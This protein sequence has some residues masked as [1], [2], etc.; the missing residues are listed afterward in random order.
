MKILF[1]GVFDTEHK[2]TN[3]SQLIAFKELGHD[4]VGYNYRK[5][6][7]LIGN[8]NRDKDLISIVKDRNFDLVVYSKCN[9]VSLETF[10]QI[11]EL[12]KTCLWF[13]DPLIT[14]EQEMREKTKLVDYFCCDKEN[15]LKEALKINKNSF[16]VC[17]GFD[18]HV[19]KPHSL[20][21]CYDISFIG[22]IYGDRAKKLES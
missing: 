9:V 6:G 15:V 21:K 17:E 11:N 14:Y 10:R 7:A 1:I 20:E 5:K 18:H 16:H 12:T 19:D 22:S 3:L 8:E 13:M 4:V 2:S